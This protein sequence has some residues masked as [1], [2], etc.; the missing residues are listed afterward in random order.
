VYFDNDARGE[1]PRNALRLL[2]LLEPR[3]A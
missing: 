3:G 1:A 2:T